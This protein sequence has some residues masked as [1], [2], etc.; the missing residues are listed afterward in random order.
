M[1]LYTQD[2]R[3]GKLFTPLGANKLLLLEFSG[4][5]MTDDVSTFRV[6]ALSEKAPV[7]LDK[8]LGKEMRVELELPAD[9]TR[10]FYLTVFGARTLGSSNGNYLYEFE[11][12]PWIWAMARRETSRIFAEQTAMDI[13]NEVVS[14]YAGLEGM[15]FRSHLINSLP[16]LEYTVQFCESDL[17]FVRRLLEQFGISFYVEMTQTKQ[18]LVMVD[19]HDDYTDIGARSFLP[20]AQSHNA[21]AEVFDVWLPQRNLTTGSVRTVDYDFK[22]PKMALDATYKDTKGYSNA[23]YEVYEYPGRFLEQGDGTIIARRRHDASRAADAIIKANGDVL[24]LGP[25]MKIALIDHPDASENGSYVCL[26]ANHHYTNG[27]YQSG[28]QQET[29]YHGHFEMTLAT[30]PV[31]PARV[32]PRPVMRGPQ[33][34]RVVNGA[35]GTLDEWGRVNV[36]FHWDSGAES[37][38]C[39]VSQMWAGSAWGTVFIPRVNMEVIVEFLDGDPDRPIVTGCVYNAVNMPPWTL[40]DK[41][42]VSGIKS[43]SM[44]GGGYNEL[45]FDDKDGAE[46][47]RMHGQKDLEVVIENNEDHD[48]K[49]DSTRKIGGN[50]KD[51]I[52]GTLT[53]TVAGAITIESKTSLTL[54]VGGSKIEMTPTEIK[55]SSLNVTVE[56]SAMLKTSAGAMADHK[57]GA[58]M[59]IG[60]VIVKIN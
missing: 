22:R 18:T 14:E 29:S 40:P 27:S 35:D 58:I 48:I 41:N 33:T 26:S 45:A 10:Y 54:K 38:P 47:I 13:I 31:A 34:A 51:D 2:S 44:G 37:M 9:K 7:D 59:K 8:L 43:N 39:R 5:E 20:V 19:N 57:G 11:L 21:G 55:I 24:S 49:R 15:A 36:S 16:M 23:S 32:T 25:G 42:T 3:G 17:S 60:A 4:T 56:A 12:H 53:Q 1:P 30:N 50:R 46:L 6:K 52:T 28:G